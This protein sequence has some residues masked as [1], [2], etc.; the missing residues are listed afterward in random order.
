MPR[1][2]EQDDHS[3]SE[4]EDEETVEDASEEEE[5]VEEETVEETPPPKKKVGRPK[6]SKTA[7]KTRPVGDGAPAKSSKPLADLNTWPKEA[8][9]LWPKILEWLGEQ[10]RSASDVLIAVHRQLTGPFVG[11][12]TE[13]SPFLG[14][15]VEGS[16]NVS[17]SEALMQ[18]IVNVYHI[19]SAGPSLYTLYFRWRA[20]GALIKTGELRL[21]SYDRIMQSLNRA[22]YM[23]AVRPADPQ[24]QQPVY[25]YPPTF[26]QPPVQPMR[27]P[28]PSQGV[29]YA[30]NYYP[31]ASPTD[32]YARESV[33][34]L[35]RE[36]AV[37]LGRF[38]EAARAQAA[39]VGAPPPPPLAAHV[40]DGQQSL[41]RTIVGV[42]TEMG[43][44]PQNNQVGV[45]NPGVQAPP[46]GINNV[47][48]RAREQVGG[49]RDFVKI[50][51][52][53]EGVRADLGIGGRDEE[54]APPAA[55]VAS[56]ALAV[57]PDPEAPPFGVKPIPFSGS[58]LSGGK[59]LNWVTRGED[60]PMTDWVLKMSAS[61]PEAA[62]SIVE[63]AMRIVDQG[64]IGGVLRKMASQ[65]QPQAAAVAQVQQ[66]TANGAALGTGA[67][68]G[69]Y[70]TA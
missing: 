24:P 16:A 18:Y 28:P 58:K 55:P 22:A 38:D 53:L 2:E 44:R 9:A 50:F 20:G 39:G 17:P 30:S 48:S 40:D 11:E 10:G 49:L 65:G 52:E 68:P 42:L 60:E 47:V 69:G 23:Q 32:P 70:P 26:G 57:V 31:P 45:G 14:S 21:D 59:P 62:I 61:N 43:F 41:V 19:T 51:K 12:A 8:T 35:R 46:D 33:E 36:M 1:V 4:E 54:E 66:N 64:A 63:M 5:S 67:P 34:G 6:G 7:T 13:L 3:S 37:L 29:G 56:A 25:A 15:Y 27:P